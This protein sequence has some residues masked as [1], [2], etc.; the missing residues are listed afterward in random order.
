MTLKRLCQI[1]PLLLTLSLV[2][3]AARAGR[4]TKPGK[5]IAPDP[6]GRMC[7]TGR[8]GQLRDVKVYRGQ[9]SHQWSSGPV[10]IRIQ[11]SGVD[12]ACKLQVVNVEAG[13]PGRQVLRSAKVVPGDPLSKTRGGWYGVRLTD[14]AAAGAGLKAASQDLLLVR[15]VNPYT[16]R[17]SRWS[18][19]RVNAEPAPRYSKEQSPSVSEQLG[20]VTQ[21][22]DWT[23]TEAFKLGNRPGHSPVWY[24]RARDQRAVPVDAGQLQVTWA[25]GSAMVT[26]PGG[27]VTTL[28]N[29]VQVESAG[30]QKGSAV[31]NIFGRI[32]PVAISTPREPVKIQVVRP[33]TG[34][35]TAT[36]VAVPDDGG[37]VIPMRPEH[38][39][40]QLSH[41][42]L[43]LVTTRGGIKL[44][45]YVSASSAGALVRF[46]NLTRDSSVVGGVKSNDRIFTRPL[47]LAPGEA[48]E[49]RVGGT[50]VRGVYT[51]PGSLHS[52][53]LAQ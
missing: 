19:V 48:F 41:R 3:T 13:R 12:P 6:K 36:Y 15:Q 18:R 43:R 40:V 32:R 22:Q 24:S 9:W 1:T 34:S 35:T 29:L 31:A 23:K 2:S 53:A 17:A 37:K 16:G 46:K 10:D 7:V 47:E 51:G 38:E 30:G 26:A 25:K 42:R 50:L 8:P 27:K 49:L 4:P 44:S 28:D 11:A 52:Q 21:H 14:T 33:G 39:P 20:I 5:S 45:G